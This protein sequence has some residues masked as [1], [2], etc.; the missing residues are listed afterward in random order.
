MPPGEK[1]T[2]SPALK[3]YKAKKGFAN[4]YFN[5]QAQTKLLD[6]HRRHGDFSG[7]TGEWSLTGEV[8]MAK[9]RGQTTRPFT[10]RLTER[11]SSDGSEVP[12]VEL[13][14]DGLNFSLEP[15]KSDQEAN[16]LQGPPGSGGLMLAFY[17]L[18]R[19]L[20]R[21]PKAFEGG[22]DHGGREPFYPPP[23]MGPVPT[24]GLADL[25]VDAEVLRTEHAAVPAKW[26]FST[27]DQSLLGFEVFPVPDDDPCEVYLSDYKSVDG[28]Q[29]PH[30]IEVRR[31]YEPYAVYTV[32][33]VKLPSK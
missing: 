19:F 26:Y 27:K 29:V 13:S 17:H 8:A 9:D 11:V 1:T 10:L 32:T 16:E 14:Q 4:Y 20:A 30:R 3:F 25:R 24:R 31:G 15:L 2:P 18:K 22:F 33:S 12:V 7:L 21:G 6:G 23:A 5:E 28:R